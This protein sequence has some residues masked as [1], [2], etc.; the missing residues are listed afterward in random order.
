MGACLLWPIFSQT[1]L[2]HILPKVINIGSQ[3]FV[4]YTVYILVTSYQYIL[5]GQVFKYNLE[6][7]V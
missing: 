5:P 6:S 1:H 2:V 4:T 7:F 3:I